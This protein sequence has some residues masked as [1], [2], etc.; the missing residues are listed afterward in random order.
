MLTGADLQTV[1]T[2]LGHVRSTK[3]REL[4]AVL[5]ALG[6]T[7]DNRLR[8]HY[9]E[10]WPDTCLVKA[11]PVDVQTRNWHWVCRVHGVWHDPMLLSAGTLSPNLR[12]VS[13]LTITPDLKTVF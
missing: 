8:V 4:I 2:L 11:V 5:L 12:P 13:Y 1:L 7:P 10:G 9:G 6:F 3:T